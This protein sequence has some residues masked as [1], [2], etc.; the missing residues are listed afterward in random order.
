MTLEKAESLVGAAIL[1]EADGQG[2]RFFLDLR[3]FERCG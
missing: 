2:K 3:E 1:A